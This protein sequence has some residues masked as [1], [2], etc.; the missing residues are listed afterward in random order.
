MIALTPAIWQ[1][2]RKVALTIC[3]LDS[4]IFLIPSLFSPFDVEPTVCKHI[5]HFPG[6]FFRIIQR[7]KRHVSA[8]IFSSESGKNPSWLRLQPF[9]VAFRPR[10]RRVDSLV[11][12]RV[13]LDRPAVRYP[14]AGNKTITKSP[15]FA[16]R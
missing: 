5:W 1:L 2:S 15:C 4:V 14:T 7:R 16:I 8:N 9:G 13:G 11:A 10:R 3:P 6:L 12:V